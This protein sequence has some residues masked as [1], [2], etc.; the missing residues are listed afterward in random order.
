MRLAVSICVLVLAAGLGGGSAVAQ[1]HLNRAAAAKG[2]PDGGKSAMKAVVRAWSARLNAGDNDGIARLFSVPATII[3]GQYVYRLITR[4]QV[5]LWHSLLPCSGHILS[6]TYHGRF[7]T[8]V[9]KLGN[10]GSTKC[11]QPGALAAARFEI[12][13]GKIVSWEQVPVPAKKA[14]PG[15]TA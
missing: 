1:R 11:D 15:T 3:Q 6:I 4:H 2:Q 7:A 9:F 12:V 8:A 10:R 13:K 14:S 5:S